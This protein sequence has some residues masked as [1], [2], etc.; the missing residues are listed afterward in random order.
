MPLLRLQRYWS[1]IHIRQL[2]GQY[3]VNSLGII[4]RKKFYRT[5][6][7]PVSELVDDI[8]LVADK[9]RD[10]KHPEVVNYRNLSNDLDAVGGVVV[11]HQQLSDVFDNFRV[12][13]NSERRHFRN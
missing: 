2:F 6:T 3:D 5:M 11:G 9:Y 10:P 13:D 12:C 7:Q 8:S 1:G 4:D